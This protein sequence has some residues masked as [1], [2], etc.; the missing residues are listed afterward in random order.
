M[1]NG[2]KWVLENSEFSYCYGKSLGILETGW[3]ITRIGYDSEKDHILIAV[4]YEESR[5]ICPVTNES[6]QIYDY[7]KARSW[8][9]MDQFD[10]KVYVHARVPR[11]M[12]SA[13]VKSVMVPWAD[14]SCRFT[15]LFETWVIK[16]L[17]ATKNQTAA[18][19][20]L[21]ISVNKV[22]RI[23]RH[24]VA[25]GMKRRG[26]VAVEH[27]SIDEKA[28]KR[29]HHYAT[30]LTDAT[31]GHVLDLGQGR[32]YKET[33]A[34]MERT[35][36]KERRA[37]VKTFTMDM[38]KPYIKVAKEVLPQALRI[39]D[40]FHLIKYLNKAVDKT[41]RREVRKYPELKYS[42]YALLKNAE[43]RTERQ[44]K[45]FQI[46]KRANY[47]V[48]RVWTLKENFKSLF[49]C[50]SRGEAIRYFR[51]WYANV[52]KYDIKEVTTV[53]RMFFKHIEGIIN[54]L[55]LNLSNAR[56][57]NLNGRIQQL[58]STGRGYR[59]FENFRAAIL[60]FYGNLDLFPHKLT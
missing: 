37:E 34:L 52:L 18:A 38:W 27:L 22:G 20:L 51:L 43:N 24:S 50:E 29:G 12:S 7:R 35:L 3:S 44:E 45:M 40:R 28:I 58:K 57:E 25:R 42:R 5:A 16:L 23:M 41:R 26:Q 31:T 56:A 36:V 9:H 32:T 30:I 11:V 19:E 47:E 2:I 53:A 54:A 59:N 48:S 14:D 13:G 21:R 1:E 39:H 55:F 8:R 4:E 46:I 6:S 10:Y 17:K 49:G 15:H 33:E 60:F